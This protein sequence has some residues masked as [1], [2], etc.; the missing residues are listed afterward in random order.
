LLRGGGLAI[1]LG[2]L[3]LGGGSLDLGAPTS[4]TTTTVPAASTTVPTIG[5]VGAPT[6]ETSQGA[7][8]TP[9]STSESTDSSDVTGSDSSARG[10]SAVTTTV[11]SAPGPPTSVATLPPAPG[12]TTTIGLSADTY[13][14]LLEAATSARFAVLAPSDGTWILASV[15]SARTD[16]AVYVATSYQHAGDFVTINQERATSYPDVPN[17]APVI[18]R[19][20]EGRLLDLGTILVV[21]W[22]EGDTALT[23]ST[24]LSRDAALALIESL[25]PIS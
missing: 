12:V 25:R 15:D 23:V 9:S 14:R 17:S 13:S 8:Q 22:V 21:R 4:S 6:T 3:L 19:A 2:G 10:T 11:S 20:V 16:R 1:L 24:N 18:V 5:Y 7:G